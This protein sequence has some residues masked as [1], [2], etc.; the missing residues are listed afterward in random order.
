M[1]T[2]VCSKKGSADFTVSVMYSLSV[3]TGGNSDKSPSS[4]QALKL[5]TV[6]AARAETRMI[7]VFLLSK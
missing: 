3:V 4:A 5:H 2:V 6:A 1:L 7:F